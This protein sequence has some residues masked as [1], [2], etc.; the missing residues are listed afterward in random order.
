MFLKLV[1]NKVLFHYG[2][3]KWQYSFNE[4]SCLGLIRKKKTFYLEDGSFI[5]V[6]ALAYYCMLFSDII[7]LYYLVPTILCYTVIIILRINST[8]FKYYVLVQD[9]YGKETKIKIKAI[10]RQTIRKQID[11]Y[12]N[13][14][15][16]QLVQKSI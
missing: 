3:K 2:T 12:L 13:Q 6:T 8:E 11:V 14:K 9:I 1:H 5:A 7:D 4:I 16:E 15:F 10:D